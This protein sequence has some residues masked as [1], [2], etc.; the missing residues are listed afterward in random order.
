M[1]IC[2]L[3]IVIALSD[4]IGKMTYRQSLIDGRVSHFRAFVVPKLWCYHSIYICSFYLMY[5][6]IEENVHTCLMLNLIP[7]E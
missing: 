7:T 2:S 3:L 6:P 4:V 1:C 5:V